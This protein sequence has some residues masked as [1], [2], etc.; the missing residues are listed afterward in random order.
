MLMECPACSHQNADGARFCSSCGALLSV[1]PGEGLVGQTLGGRYAVRRV[2]GEGGMG[3][4]YEAEQRMGSHL[5][6]VAIKTL[7]PEL[8]H[9]H[10][11]VSRFYR[12]CGTVAQLEHPNTIRF[13]DFGETPDGALYI[14]MEF[15]SG[16]ALTDAIAQGP[17]PAARV[18]KILRQVCGAL[19]EAH[20]LGIIHRDLKP[21]NIILT[22]RAGERDVVKLLDFGIAARTGPN[23]EGQTK[24]TQQGT[25]LGTPPYM[26]PE[27][28]AGQPLDGRSDIYS[29]GVIAY[30]MLTGQLPFDADS[31]WMWAHKHMTEPPRSLATFPGLDIPPV[32]VDAVMRALAK[33]PDDRPRNALEF[34]RELSAGEL[35]GFV[36]LAPPEERS[37][38]TSPMGAPPPMRQVATE[39]EPLVFAPAVRTA[40]AMAAPVAPPVPYRRR[41]RG[42]GWIV[43]AGSLIGAAAVAALLVFGQPGQPSPTLPLTATAPGIRCSRDHRRAAR[44]YDGRADE[45]ATRRTDD[46][47]GASRCAQAAEPPD[48]AE[49]AG[50]AGFHAVDADVPGAGAAAARVGQPDADAAAYR[51]Y[52][53]PSAAEPARTRRRRRSNRS[54]PPVRPATRRARRRTRSPEATRRPR[55]RCT[56]AAAPPAEAR[57]RS[58]TRCRGSAAPRRRWCARARSA[59]T[60]PAPAAPRAPPRR[61]ARAPLRRQRCRRRAADVIDVATSMPTSEQPDAEH[62][63]HGADGD[64]RHRR[65]LPRA[66]ARIGEAELDRG[67]AAGLAALLA[68]QGEVGRADRGL[69][70][71]FVHP[72]VSLHSFRRDVEGDRPRRFKCAEI[73]PFP[74][75]PTTRGSAPARARAPCGAGRRSSRSTP[76]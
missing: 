6:K 24:L 7:L 10:A 58:A 51:P 38:D 29:L 64:R 71:L 28:L 53:E 25:V 40:S 76:S 26:S 31:P 12:E 16:Q 75:S 39:D 18:L 52:P 56:T 49:P 60:A 21:D 42:W 44:R 1:E 74:C 63:Q 34:Y 50:A 3:V 67:E 69:V 2:I 65:D 35:E 4:V 5:R 30:E 54:P 73:G 47:A 8:S 57:P 22:D 62:E 13:Y 68:R 33:R 45:R 15:V 48:R 41:S 37:P 46:D 20:G 43:A 32:I 36:D 61:L 72:A 59:A 14:A 55:S 11:L 17:M 66:R 19:H 23:A 70:R 9:D 27:Q